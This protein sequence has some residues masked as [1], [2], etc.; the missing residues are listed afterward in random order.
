MSA[1]ATP[2][3]AESGT[4]RK[5]GWVLSGLAGA[6]LLFDAVGKILKLGPVEDSAVELGLPAHIIVPIGIV[7]LICTALY[8]VPR[9]A[10]LG[11]VLLT[12][13]LGG[14]VLTN[15]RVEKPLFSTVLFAV[16]VGIV[17]WAG[18]YL[19]DRRVRELLP[20]RRED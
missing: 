18:L 6:F 4:A 11:A 20:L 5:V 7:L 8:L 16:Y 17:V 1:T 10:P 12:G 13:Y 19:R 15:W 2:V 3:A 14:A 9:T